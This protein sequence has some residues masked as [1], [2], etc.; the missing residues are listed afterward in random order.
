VKAKG[1]P[2]VIIG[3]CGDRV[4]VAVPPGCSAFQIEI[5]KSLLRDLG[6]PVPRRLPKMA[7]GVSCGSTRMTLSPASGCDT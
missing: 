5:R 4:M 6:L 1:L 3:E 7:S 2:G